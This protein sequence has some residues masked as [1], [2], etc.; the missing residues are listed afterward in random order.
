MTD[1]LPNDN[2][3]ETRAEFIAKI[4]KRYE[5]PMNL[6]RYETIEHNKQDN[7]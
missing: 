2:S 7:D 4:A 5:V 3:K 6:I 1:V